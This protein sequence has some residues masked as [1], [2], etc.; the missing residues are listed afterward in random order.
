MSGKGHA[1]PRRRTSRLVALARWSGRVPRNALLRGVA[2][3]GQLRREGYRGHECVHVEV[4]APTP[5]YATTNRKAGPARR[6]RAHQ[7]RLRNVV[8]RST[9]A[10]ASRAGVELALEQPST[11]PLYVKHP[12][13]GEIKLNGHITPERRDAAHRRDE[14][15]AEARRRRKLPPADMQRDLET[16]S[17]L[18]RL[19]MRTLREKSR[20][21]IRTMMKR[22]DA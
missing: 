1:T 5:R 13:W 10:M 16:A 8:L 15:K 18:E 4:D 3:E 7:A 6:R 17:M 21:G 11:A 14:R 12:E 2:S 9:S 19:L 22:G 20:S